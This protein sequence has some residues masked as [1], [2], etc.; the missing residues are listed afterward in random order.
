MP[1]ARLFWLLDECGVVDGAPSPHALPEAAAAAARASA[2]FAR[3]QLLPPKGAKRNPATPLRAVQLALEALAADY[4]AAAAAAATAADADAALAVLR[5]LPW[6]LRPATALQTEL[7]SW[8]D[9]VGKEPAAG[10][11]AWRR[12]AAGILACAP[13]LFGAVRTA[14]RAA[15]LLAAPA[16]AAAAVADDDEPPIGPLAPDWLKREPSATPSVAAQWLCLAAEVIGAPPPATDNNT[17]TSAAPPAEPLHDAAVAAAAAAAV[18][19]LV[20]ATGLDELRLRQRLSG[21]VMRA[22]HDALLRVDTDHR[23]HAT[24]RLVGALAHSITAVRAPA[25]AK[26]RDSH[27]MLPLLLRWA[28]V[29]DPPSRAAALGALR[30]CVDELPAPEVRW[31][32]ELLLHKLRSL[33]VFREPIV[34]AALLPALL[35]AWR[36]CAPALR[37]VAD[38]GR[39]HA[40]AA[41]ELL[42]DLER[43]LMYAVPK[44]AARR[45]Y[46]R[47]LA[48]WAPSLGARVCTHLAA[49]LELSYAALD[50]EAADYAAIAAKAAEHAAATPTPTARH[51][52]ALDDAAAPLA[53]AVALVDA[54]LRAAPPRA[55]AHAAMASRHVLSAYARAAAAVAAVPWWWAAAADGAAAWPIAAE[56]GELRRGLEAAGGA[57][58]YRASHDALREAVAAAAESAKGGDERAARL[59]TAV[60]AL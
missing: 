39:A 26:C 45:V 28:E 32:S 38:D 55:P 9:G 44:R 43:E 1:A 27:K 25:L 58:G 54:L 50:A 48:A 17:P 42:D 12:R 8:A 53:A 33:L 24:R 46:T 34:V 30:H 60:L 41:A 3:D 19:A 7:D 16:G 23:A 5:R 11:L 6:A 47:E 36:V 10:A 13:A 52:R 2:S 22:T 15:D 40:A 20:A 51:R 21:D 57:D 37:D 59:R 35:A 29:L 49:L 14:R 4:A 18:G 31:H 56:V